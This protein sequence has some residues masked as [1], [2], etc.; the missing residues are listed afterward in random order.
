MKKKHRK[1]MHQFSHLFQTKNENDEIH[2]TLTTYMNIY[3]PTYFD[4]QVQ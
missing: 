4:E 1:K 3:I 2:T